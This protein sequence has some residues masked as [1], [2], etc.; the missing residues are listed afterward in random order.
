MNVHARFL[1]CF[2]EDNSFLSLIAIQMVG[3]KFEQLEV[4]GHKPTLNEFGMEMDM[5]CWPLL[6]Q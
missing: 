2:L 6:T 5:N 4:K 1:K 3:W